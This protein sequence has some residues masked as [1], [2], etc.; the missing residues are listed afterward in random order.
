VPILPPLRVIRCEDFLLFFSDL[1]FEIGFLFLL[2]S[3]LSNFCS[4]E[5]YC[6]FWSLK[7]SDI[8]VPKSNYQA[9]LAKASTTEAKESVQKEWNEAEARV[10]RMHSRLAE[11]SASWFSMGERDGERMCCD[12]NLVM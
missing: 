8:C 6:L 9:L 11:Q 10:L 4:N 12:D 5:F 7:L 2:T 3:L 1:L